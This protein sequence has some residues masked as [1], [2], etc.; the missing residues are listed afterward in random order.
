[1]RTVTFVDRP[2]DLGKY[3]IER[4]KS[5]DLEGIVALYEPEATIMLGPGRS[6]TGHD[7]IRQVLKNYLSSRPIDSAL[8]Q[9]TIRHGRLALTLRRLPNGHSSVEV[10]R[11]Q[12]DGT[13]L[14]LINC[15][16][17]A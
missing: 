12:S 5:G 3:F 6:I 4:M 15:P 10:A 1:M 2:E 9:Q 8:Q 14:W 11:C 16:Q 7:A 17:I 13:W